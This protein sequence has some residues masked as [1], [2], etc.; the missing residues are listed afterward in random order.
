VVTAQYHF[1]IRGRATGPFPLDVI[2]QLVRRGQVGRAHE[3]ALDGV[4]WRPAAEFPEIFAGGAVAAAVPQVD[5]HLP[6][7]AGPLPAR[8]PEAP[9]TATQPPASTSPLT[10]IPRQP[11]GIGV[12]E[13]IVVACLAAI[14]LGVVVGVAQ[15]VIG[16]RAATPVPGNALPETQTIDAAVQWLADDGSMVSAVAE[17]SV[18]RPQPAKTAVNPPAM[19]QEHPDALANKAFANLQKGLDDKHHLPV[20]GLKPDDP[21]AFATLTL[22]AQSVRLCDV[23]SA[24][25]DVALPTEDFLVAAHAAY[26][27]RADF[28]ADSNPVARVWAIYADLRQTSSPDV[29][30]DQAPKT[31]ALGRVLHQDGSLRFE[32]DA[33]AV[34]QSD[35]VVIA[36]IRQGLMTAALKIIN[37]HDPGQTTWV[38]LCAPAANPRVVMEKFFFDKDLYPARPNQRPKRNVGKFDVPLT[39]WRHQ[40]RLQATAAGAKGVVVDREPGAVV[41]QQDDASPS[42]TMRWSTESGDEPFL[43]TTF[44]ID[45]DISSRVL[46]LT[47]AELQGEWATHRRLR[48]IAD[49]DEKMWMFSGIQEAKDFRND[50]LEKVHHSAITALARKFAS[51]HKDKIDSINSKPK[52]LFSGVNNIW[53]NERLLL[54]GGTSGAQCWRMAL[55]RRLAKTPGYEAWLSIEHPPPKQEP[56]PPSPKELEAWEKKR[57]EK[58]SQWQSLLVKKTDMVSAEDLPKFLKFLRGTQDASAGENKNTAF[59]YSLEALIYLL[60]EELERLDREKRKALALI[61]SLGDG[62]VSLEGHVAI[63]F[64]SAGVTSVVGRFTHGS[65]WQHTGSLPRR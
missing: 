7:E 16:S 41:G 17:A 11:V 42:F 13:G 65:D 28:A 18:D 8:E 23:G 24:E 50:G 15:G 34:Q 64:P 44:E 29:A 55:L 46:R 32:L 48:P 63:G 40:F 9:T 33:Q 31:V 25:I 45:T 26:R 4:S 56:R 60:I 59:P 12:E 22:V 51:T 47:K 49:A 39:P 3:V 54:T 58:E 37:R 52:D 30:P 27:L 36:K 20:E 6:P 38:Q 14:A 57:R 5:H 35:M 10:G 62:T 43:E 2:R 1:R 21:D 61:E 19:K 53:V